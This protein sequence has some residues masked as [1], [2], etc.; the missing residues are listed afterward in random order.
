[1][2]EETEKEISRLSHEMA[3]A[4]L[5]A[6]KRIT[7]LERELR[8]EPV[9]SPTGTKVESDALKLLQYLETNG[10]LTSKQ[11]KKI[12]KPKNHEDISRAMKY[13]DRKFVEVNLRSRHRKT[14]PLILE[15]KCSL[16]SLHSVVQA[17]MCKQPL[18]H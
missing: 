5:E 11:A 18:K 16:H 13:L 17:E 8:E 7:S 10:R 1:M 3:S 14:D 2:D 6:N 12:L 9:L 4:L 15:C